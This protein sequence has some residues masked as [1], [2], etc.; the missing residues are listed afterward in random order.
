MGPREAAEVC[1][2][3]T[4]ESGELNDICFITIS[5]WSFAIFFLQFLSF[6][7]SFI[8]MNLSFFLKSLSCFI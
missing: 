6:F 8:K 2:P 5:P 7:P 1:C 4:W 3:L